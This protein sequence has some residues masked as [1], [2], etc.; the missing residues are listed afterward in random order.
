M[1][2]GG[3]QRGMVLILKHINTCVSGVYQ[4]PNITGLSSNLQILAIVNM[5]IKT[6]SMNL[7]QVSKLR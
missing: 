2:K 5:Y 7:G 6:C 4:C 1:N 3:E